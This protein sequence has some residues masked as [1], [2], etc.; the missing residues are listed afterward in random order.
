MFEKYMKCLAAGF[1]TSLALLM[2]WLLV[3]HVYRMQKELTHK[4]QANQ[5]EK[6]EVCK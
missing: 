5:P 4:S 2:V 3:L 6:I 1:A